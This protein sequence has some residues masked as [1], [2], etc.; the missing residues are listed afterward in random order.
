[1][2]FPFDVHSATVSDSHL[3]CHPRPCQS[4]QGHDTAWPSIEGLWANCPRWASSGYDAEFHEVL[5]RR[6]PISDAGG[7][8]E[9]KHRLS[10]TRKIVV[11]AHYKKDDLLH[12]WTRSRIFPATMR[13]FTKARHCRSRAGTRHG[14]SELTHGLAW[15]RHA[16]CESALTPTPHWPDD[17]II[18]HSHTC[19]MRLSLSASLSNKTKNFIPYSHFPCNCYSKD[20]RCVGLTTLPLS[21]VECR[22]ILG[23][24]ICWSPEGLS[25]SVMGLL[26][27]LV[28]TVLEAISRLTLGHNGLEHHH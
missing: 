25:R 19:L 21:C 23:A 20:G 28:R 11:A 26:Y 5:I 12:C 3:P 1:V 6:I 18:C 13:T 16:M 24:S 9:T 14:T 15:D 10:W 8:C 17:P 27:I 4:S 22:Q 2:S 7:Q